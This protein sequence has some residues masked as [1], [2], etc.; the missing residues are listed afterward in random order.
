M[1]K[2]Y[3]DKINEIITKLKNNQKATVNK[4]KNDI[5]KMKSSSFM[6]PQ[7][8]MFETYFKNLI[9]QMET[10]L[11]T[12]HGNIEK[13]L[14]NEEAEIT[15]ESIEKVKQLGADQNIPEEIRAIFNQLEGIMK[16]RK[17]KGK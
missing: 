11:T 7:M 10:Q 17:A 3:N 12:L 1:D 8:A 16:E 2:E 6:G 5:G 14:L 4:L 13:E 9:M 15:E